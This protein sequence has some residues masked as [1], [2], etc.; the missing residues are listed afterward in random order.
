MHAHGLMSDNW[1]YWLTTS[2]RYNLSHLSAKGRV[3]FCGIPFEHA[4]PLTSRV[5][6]LC[7]LGRLEARTDACVSLCGNV[8][9]ICWKPSC[10]HAAHTHT[11]TH[12]VRHTHT[13]S[14]KGYIGHIPKEG[15]SGKSIFFFF[16]CGIAWI[17]CSGCSPLFLLPSPSIIPSPRFSPTFSL[18]GCFT[19]QAC[20]AECGCGEFR[21]CSVNRRAHFH[22]TVHLP[23]HTLY[24]PL[25]AKPQSHTN[26]LTFL[27]FLPFLLFPCW[28]VCH[29]REVR[30]HVILQ[31]C[32]ECIQPRVPRRWMTTN[33][34]SVTGFQPHEKYIKPSARLEMACYTV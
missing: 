5:K 11:C 7:L 20:E 1:N 12:T 24:F 25:S 34:T 14:L 27:P 2:L 28:A 29:G 22:A 16:L 30:H 6:L 10:Q 26:T 4:L 9:F 18:T 23:F 8:I 19:G 31:W 13:H 3:C 17:L 33:Q 32:V 15:K 21:S